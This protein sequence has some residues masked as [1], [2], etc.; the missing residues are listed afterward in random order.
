M[1]AIRLAWCLPTQFVGSVA[2]H[3]PAPRSD[4]S[5]IHPLRFRDPSPRIAGR[6]KTIADLI[7]PVVHEQEWECLEVIVTEATEAFRLSRD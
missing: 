5:W 1:A 7:A 3:S 2:H 4:S 6:G